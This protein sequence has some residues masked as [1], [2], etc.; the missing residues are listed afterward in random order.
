MK[1]G[2]RNEVDV[3]N[4]VANLRTL[5]PLHKLAGFAKGQ[6]S[7][8]FECVLLCFINPILGNRYGPGV[9]SCQENSDNHLGWPDAHPP[10]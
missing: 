10:P 5:T 6:A 4:S 1:K 2:A 8:H 3:C 9:S 7:L